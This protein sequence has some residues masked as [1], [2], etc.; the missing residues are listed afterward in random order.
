[1]FK[2]TLYTMPRCMRCRLTKR[3]LASHN[4]PFMTVLLDP[5]DKERQQATLDWLHNQLHAQQAPVVT[6]TNDRGALIDH[7][8]GFDVKRLAQYEPS[9]ATPKATS[10]SK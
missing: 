2:L 8:T 5:A 10:I 6:I 3:W 4:T 7:W 9:L 1:M